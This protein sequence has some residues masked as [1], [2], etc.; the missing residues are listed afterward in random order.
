MDRSGA[1]FL[2]VV[3]QIE[4]RLGATPVPLQLAIGA[5]EEF[6]GVIDLM[7]MKAIYW[8]KDSMGVQFEEKDIP[9]DLLDEA[10]EYREQMVEVAAESS[11]EL[12]D[13]YLENGDL[14]NEQIKTALRALTIAN[15]IVPVMCGSAFKNKGV[16]AMLDGI[17]DYLPSP[18]EVPAITGI[19]AKENEV[20]RQ[21]DDGEPFSALAFKIAT[22]PFV[23]QL[24]FFRVYS[25]V[26]KTGDA[27]FNPIK[28]KK[29][30]IG[31]ILQM[32]SNNREEIKDG[33]SRSSDL[34][35]G[36]AED[37]VRP[38]KNDVGFN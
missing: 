38:R 10:T 37:T 31:R 8:D 1:D 2:R 17:V 21:S 7:K 23:G 15:E 25:G 32:H 3:E 22:D 27:V 14:S 12:M 29:E 34:S 26:M 18:V 28:G 13:E 30:R 36:R 9:A 5:E 35:G 19:D 33:I 4:T 16:Q 20:E 11:E 6:E 24:V